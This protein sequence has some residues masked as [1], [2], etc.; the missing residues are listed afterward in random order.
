MTDST[1]TTTCSVGVISLAKAVI[2]GTPS[3]DLIATILKTIQKVNALFTTLVVDQYKRHA[4]SSSS[5]PWL[6]HNPGESDAYCVNH[7]RVESLDQ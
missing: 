2:R 5:D 3:T 7:P 4:I 1:A 6:R